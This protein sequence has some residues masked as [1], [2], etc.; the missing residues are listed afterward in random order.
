MDAFWNKSM[1]SKNVCSG[2]DIFNL[3]YFCGCCCCCTNIT[4][5]EYSEWVKSSMK[6]FN[7]GH[8]KF[9]RELRDFKNVFGMVLRIEFHSLTTV[10]PKKLDCCIDVNDAVRIITSV[11]SKLKLSEMFTNKCCCVKGIR[12]TTIGDIKKS[13]NAIE[14]LDFLKN[15]LSGSKDERNCCFGHLV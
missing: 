3:Y 12:K 14:V 5:I 4:F 9:Q 11:R 6:E 1:I 10:E 15:K 2:K 7:C 8:W 13:T